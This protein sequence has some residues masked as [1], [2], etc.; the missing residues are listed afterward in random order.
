MRRRGDCIT[1]MSTIGH[2]KIISSSD[3]NEWFF[4][5]LICTNISKTRY[6]I[7][8]E[9]TYISV[10]ALHC[11]IGLS[12][13]IGKVVASHAEGCK[14]DSR[15]W[16]SCTDL[17]IL[18]RGYCPWG[19]GMRPVNWIYRLWRHCPLW[20]T[21]TRSSQLGYFSRLLQ[22]VNNWPLILWW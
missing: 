5:Y 4:F 19:W 12:G 8:T 3:I 20:S 14:I 9:C 22:V 15:L 21:A 10:V 7:S 1:R 2:F 13:R 18:C 17:H 16:L 6:M 11:G